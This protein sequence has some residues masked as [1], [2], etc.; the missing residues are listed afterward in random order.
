MQAKTCH[1]PIWKKN[2][3]KSQFHRFSIAALRFGLGR[4]WFLLYIIQSVR[5]VGMTWQSKPCLQNVSMCK[6][7]M[8][9]C[10][11]TPLRVA[12]FRQQSE[13]PA[14]MGVCAVA[15]ALRRPF[16]VSYNFQWKI[17]YPDLT[18]AI[19]GSCGWWRYAYHIL[20]LCEWILKGFILLR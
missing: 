9:L 18:G 15:L 20:K 8:C 10:L 3:P 6:H 12:V 7:N 14:G 1:H 19:E 11:S 13:A 5:K 2:V 4:S 16:F 17:I